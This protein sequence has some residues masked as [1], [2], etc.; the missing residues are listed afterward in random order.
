MSDDEK[1]ALDLILDTKEMTLSKQLDKILNVL[2]EHSTVLKGQ[3][4]L[5]EEIG[6]QIEGIESEIEKLKK[7]QSA[8][9]LNFSSVHHAFL[10]VAQETNFF[11][12][13]CEERK[14]VINDFIEESRNV[15][16]I[17]HL[18]KLLECAGYPKPPTGEHPKV[19]D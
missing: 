18:L 19:E 3:T 14:N 4:N 15:E 11:M 10:K 13:R 8:L 16:D 5:I 7:Q 12:R 17:K 2:A 9:S 6:E 1:E